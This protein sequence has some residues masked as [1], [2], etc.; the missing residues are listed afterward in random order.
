MYKKIIIKSLFVFLLLSNYFVKAND[1]ADMAGISE[2]AGA[3][4]EKAASQLAADTGKVAENIQG[5]TEAL[6]KADSDLGAALDTSI[7][8]AE[9]A[10]A[11]AQDSLAKGDITAAVQTMSL[12]E[13]VA[14]VA[15]S[16]VPDPNALDMSGINFEDNF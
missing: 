13:S 4:A 9:S 12:V 15:L 1:L 2:A 8:Q 3:S 10:I 7:A 11:F 16:A 5:A 6:G 14:D